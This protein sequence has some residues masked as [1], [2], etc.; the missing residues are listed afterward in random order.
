LTTRAIFF[1]GSRPKLT[2]IKLNK[3][4]KN[5]CKKP[6]KVLTKLSPKLLVQ[7]AALKDKKILRTL[8]QKLLAPRKM[9]EVFALPEEAQQQS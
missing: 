4:K 1:L 6:K 7:K 9:P 8:L 3:K 5:Y 2:S